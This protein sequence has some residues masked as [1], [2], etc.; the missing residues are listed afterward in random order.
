[1]LGLHVDGGRAKKSELLDGL[2]FGVPT[3]PPVKRMGR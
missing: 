2:G 3:G 1:M